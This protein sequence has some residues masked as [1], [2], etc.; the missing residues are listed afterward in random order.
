MWLFEVLKSCARVESSR[1]AAADIKKL[2][3]THLN[4]TK[5]KE[6]RR[7][8]NQTAE[9]DQRNER[10]QRRAQTIHTTMIRREEEMMMVH[11]CALITSKVR[12][13]SI[14]NIKRQRERERVD[15]M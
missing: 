8:S 5:Q 13:H 2:N 14:D 4:V 1:V 6:I 10:H 3:A 9:Q 15:V 7:N 11:I 12:Y